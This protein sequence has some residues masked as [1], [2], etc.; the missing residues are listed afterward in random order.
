MEPGSRRLL[1]RARLR[2][3]RDAAAALGYQA[4]LGAPWF[5]V[6]GYPVYHPPAFFWWGFAYDAYAPHVFENGAYIAAAGGLA[7]V[8]IAIAMSV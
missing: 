6:V 1:D 2:L 5:R 3:G 4:Q 7:S 8:V